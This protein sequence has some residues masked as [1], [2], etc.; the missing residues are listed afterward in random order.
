MKH[1][2]I[3]E[4]DRIITS[5]N[6]A[7]AHAFIV[8]HGGEIPA[9]TTDWNAV[10]SAARRSI[11]SMRDFDPTYRYDDGISKADATVTADLIFPR[12]M[13]RAALNEPTRR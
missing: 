11:A 8:K 4:R 5:G 9:D 3:E 13:L 12:S 1:P 6:A 10:F 2:I 7:Q